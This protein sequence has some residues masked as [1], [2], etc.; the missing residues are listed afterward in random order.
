M[1]LTLRPIEVADVTAAGAICHD[2]FRA[3][4]ERHNF[5]PDFP[6][7][8]VATGLLRE[9]SAWPGI[10]GVVALLD[11]RMAGSNF[12]DER[13]PIVGLG[14]ITVDPTVQNS[15]V[16]R[17]LMQ[18]MIDRAAERGA[19]GLRLVQSG[20]HARSLCLYAKLGFA[21]REPL[22]NMQGQPLGITIPGY[23]VRP[24]A[25][26]D[27]EG[28]DR[29][30]Q[31][32]HGHARG[33]DLREAIGKGTAAVVERGGRITGYTTQIAFF[34]HAVGETNDDVKALIGAA[35]SF[36]GPGFLLPI[37]NA[38]LFRWCLDQGLQMVQ[39]MT[40]M[41]LGLYNE[42]QGAYLPSILF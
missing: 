1:A 29:L 28:C 17:A 21:P 13:A 37:R 40:L 22:A 2:A 34:G 5:P 36:A 32:V 30:C 19:P 20:Y 41:T 35:T 3:I 15:G 24:A 38:E 27:A 9:L 8:D 39:P 16:G 7:R 6:D 42:S 10:Y 23:A 11:G 25:E 31:A 12:V 4:A 26:A 33:R 18:H 14:P